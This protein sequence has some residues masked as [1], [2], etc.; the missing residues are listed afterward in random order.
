MLETVVLEMVECYRGF[1][2]TVD[3]AS[4]PATVGPAWPQFCKRRSRLVTE[5]ASMAGKAA[6]RVT[7]GMATGASGRGLAF[8]L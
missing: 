2:A 3:P 6:A 7:R 4:P 1:A 5:F 8:G